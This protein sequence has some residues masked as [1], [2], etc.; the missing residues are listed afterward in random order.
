MS[1][2]RISFVLSRWDS[3]VFW[4]QDESYIDDT[5]MF[6]LLLSSPYSKSGNLHFPKLC[7]RGGAQE[8][9]REHGHHSWPE[10]ATGMFH[11]TEHHGHNENWREVV[12]RGLSL[13]GGGLGTGQ[14][15]ASNCTVDHLFLLG[16]IHTL[17]FSFQLLLLLLLSSVVIL[18]F[19]LFQLLNCFSLNSGVL[20]FSFFLICL[21][22]VGGCTEWVSSCMV[23]SCY[24]R[25]LSLCCALT[26]AGN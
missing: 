20:L 14:R 16:I 1:W 13:L 8:P 15:V 26:P 10:L 24:C 17:S 11:T 21:S 7:Q 3:A 12:R 23:L 18:Y 9:G 19:V 5:L 2:E 22:A 25:S 6:R 4:I